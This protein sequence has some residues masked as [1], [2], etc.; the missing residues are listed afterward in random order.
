MDKKA[1]KRDT[2]QPIPCAAVRYI[3]DGADYIGVRSPSTAWKIA[4]TDADFQATVTL[5]K[6]GAMTMALTEELDRFL[7]LKKAKYAELQSE[8]MKRVRAHRA[9]H[10]GE[11][12]KAKGAAS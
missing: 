1:R 7:A 11:F 6:I 12:D 10:D 5:F 2:A 4:K 8:R 9:S 3:P